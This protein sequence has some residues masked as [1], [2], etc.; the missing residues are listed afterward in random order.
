MILHNVFFPSLHPP[1]QKKFCPVWLTV[2]FITSARGLHGQFSSDMTNTNTP[3][4][5]LIESLHP[6]ERKFLISFKVTLSTETW[7]GAQ[8]SPSVFR[9]GSG[10]LYIA[11]PVSS[12]LPSPPA[13]SHTC[14]DQPFLVGGPCSTTTRLQ[15]ACVNWT[16]T[17]PVVE[18]IIIMLLNTCHISLVEYLS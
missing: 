11:R 3:D 15:Q 18:R 17:R 12:L 10:I 14:T 9:C 7:W 2:L 5:T 1:P 4:P 13:L 8:L 6:V 16:W